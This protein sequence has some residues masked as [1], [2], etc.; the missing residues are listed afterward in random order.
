MN[1]RVEHRSQQI[2]G[3]GNS[4][5]NAL[6]INTSTNS[7]FCIDLSNQ[8]VDEHAIEFA[9]VVRTDAGVACKVTLNTR[10]PELCAT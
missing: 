10:A 5:H 4:G 9:I 2:K 7:S 3:L 1:A 8:L 6:Y